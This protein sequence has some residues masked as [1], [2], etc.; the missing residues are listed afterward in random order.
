MGRAYGENTVRREIKYA[1]HP[2]PQITAYNSRAQFSKKMG[3]R[4]RQLGI[5]WDY[6]GDFANKTLPYCSVSPTLEGTEARRS[7]RSEGNWY[8]LAGPLGSQGPV[9]PIDVVHLGAILQGADDNL[10]VK[11]KKRNLYDWAPIL[12]KYDQKYFA[13]RRASSIGGRV[14]LHGD[15]CVN[16]IHRRIVSRATIRKLGQE[17]TAC[18]GKLTRPLTQIFGKDFPDPCLTPIR[19]IPLVTGAR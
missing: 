12:D 2:E 11:W 3:I 15:K 9:L 19:V 6:L 4:F 16:C 7:I 5:S 1:A 13:P 18:F 10:R 8:H 17:L 14:R